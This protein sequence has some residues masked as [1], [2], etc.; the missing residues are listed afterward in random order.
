MNIMENEKIDK[1]RLVFFP[2]KLKR[3]WKIFVT[4][5]IFL[6]GEL[7]FVISFAYLQNSFFVSL[8][9]EISCKGS[10]LY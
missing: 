8:K 10:I 2:L 7:D 9:L 1:K 4:A 5:D 3:V 6:Y